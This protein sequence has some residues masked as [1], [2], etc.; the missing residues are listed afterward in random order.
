MN[1]TLKSTSVFANT[2]TLPKKTISTIKDRK[3]INLRDRIAI[4]F[5]ADLLINI[6]LYWLGGVYWGIVTTSIL[7]AILVG[8]PRVFYMLG[9]HNQ[10]HSLRIF[11]PFYA[12]LLLMIAMIVGEPSNIHFGFVTIIFTSSAFVANNQERN[13]ILAS[14]LT[15]MVVCMYLFK[16]T[17]PLLSYPYPFIGSLANSVTIALILYIITIHYRDINKNQES[18]VASG[19]ELYRAVLHGAMDAVITFDE[20]AAISQWN[21]QAKHLFGYSEEE[22]LGQNWI[23]LIIPEQDRERYHQLIETTINSDTRRLFYQRIEII[24]LRR[25]GDKFPIEI[26]VTPTLHEGKYIFTAFLRDVTKKRQSE[27]EMQEMN[28]ELQRF[29]S[30]A[31]HDMKEPLR[32]ISSFSNLLERKVRD[33]PDT[34]EY[35]HFIKDASQ[36]M[37]QLLD[38]L[39]TYARAGKNMEATQPIDLNIVLLFVKN[40]LH[41]LIQ[42]SNAIIETDNLPLVVGHQTPFLQLFQNIISNGIKYQNEGVQPYIQIRCEELNQKYCISISDNGIGMKEEYLEKIF[43]PFT[44]LHS[45]QNYEG[46]GIGLAICKRITNRYGGQLRVESQ[47]GEGTTFY[48]EFPKEVEKC[49]EVPEGVLVEN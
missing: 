41:N 5:I 48:L 13:I 38:D 1:T 21:R 32:T 23:N 46:T 14:A 24:A 22:I 6:F 45:R 37:S 15:G 27:Q 39:I 4:P 49:I 31:S 33:R 2:T 16:Y 25:N 9:W 19:R 18:K 30:M 40:N 17:E 28:M 10:P 20:H 34:H 43:E 35:L 47:I 36:R 3:F 7:L 8:M 42:R 44:R 12:C 29:A 11:L 26:A